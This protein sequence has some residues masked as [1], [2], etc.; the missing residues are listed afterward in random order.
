MSGPILATWVDHKGQVW[1][2]ITSTWAL[3]PTRIKSH[4]A[5]RAFVH[6]RDGYR[7]A[8]CGAKAIRIPVDYDGSASL[9]VMTQAR[10][11]GRPIVRNGAP[12]LRRAILFVDH[13]VSRSV[14]GRN[15]PENL[16]SLCDPCNTIKGNTLDRAAILLK[17]SAAHA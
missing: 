5:L 4:A 3:K 1:P 13:I 8:H 12:V 10:R 14:G 2:A 11:H 6:F 9:I 7:C 17:R 15:T 16:Q